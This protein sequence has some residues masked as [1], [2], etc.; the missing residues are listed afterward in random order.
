[1]IKDMLVEMTK[2]DP[3]LLSPEAKHLFDT[4]MGILDERDELL[5]RNTKALEYIELNNESLYT[6]DLDYDLD[7]NGYLDYT[8]SS[9]REDLKAI[10]NGDYTL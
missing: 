2:M 8:P 7:D 10:L 6:A 4:I 5:K 3:E 1:M 9:F